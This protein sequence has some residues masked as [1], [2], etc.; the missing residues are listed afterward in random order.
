MKRIILFVALLSFG[1]TAQAT[2]IRATANLDYGQEV[3]PSNTDPS[4]ARGFARLVFDTVENTVAIRARIRGIS[5]SDITFPGGPLQFGVAG[6]FH[7]HLAAKGA[8]GP[9]VVPFNLESFFRDTRRGLAVRALVGF[10][11][12]LL[13]SLLAGDLYLNLHTLDYGSGEIRGQISAQVPEPST[14][15]LLALAGV[16]LIVM[17]RKV[18]SQSH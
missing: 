5:V 2:L 14:L 18:T 1:A 11:P 15:G 13:D 4:N 17:R 7:I 8:N 10:N 16:G 12:A 6:P 9:V 3:N